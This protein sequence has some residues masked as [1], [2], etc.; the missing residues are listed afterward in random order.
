MKRLLAI[1]LSA[2]ILCSLSG[3]R[4][5]SLWN[6]DSSCFSYKSEER[7]IESKQG[8][9]QDGQTSKQNK[10]QSAASSKRIQA[11]AIKQS[12]ETKSTAPSVDYNRYESVRIS[13][14]EEFQT[15][16]GDSKIAYSFHSEVAP[17]QYYQYNLLTSAGKAV[18]KT[19]CHAVEQ[20]QTAADLTA[21][22]CSSD[23]AYT[24]Y[25]A[26]MA[27]HPQYFHL[28]KSFTYRYGTRNGLVSQLILIYTDGAVTD[29]YAGNGKVAQIADRTVIAAQIAA[30]QDKIFEIAAQIPSYQTDVEKEKWIYD[31]VQDHVSYAADVTDYRKDTVRCFDAYGALVDGSAICEGYTKLFQ[32]LCYSV[33]IN[34][35]QVYGFAEGESHMWNAVQLDSLWYML[36]VTWDDPDCGDLHGYDYFNITSSQLAADHTVENDS[37]VSPVC[38]ADEHAFYRLFAMNVESFSSPPVNYEMILDRLANSSDRYLCVYIGNVSGDWEKYLSLQIF[39]SRSSVQRYIKEKRLAIS[40]NSS[41]YVGRSYQYIPIF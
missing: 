11:P 19:I 20:G 37:L 17:S 32:S 4:A 33:G 15:I 35:T 13:D 40:F 23:M 39:S 16:A 1:L 24:V 31:Y 3:C 27:D 34:A 10:M 8:S 30:F 14:E 7:T 9:S 41:Y 25:Q 36:D 22:H 26:V 29:R 28:A 38:T 5:F 2:S 6:D 21:F 12:A 18:Y